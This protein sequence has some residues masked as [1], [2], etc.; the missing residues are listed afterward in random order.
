[1][2]RKKRGKWV[3]WSTYSLVFLTVL[4]IGPLLTM[5]SCTANLKGHWSTANRESTKQAPDPQKNPE[6]V[7]QVYAARAYS[8]RGIFGVHMWFAVKPAAATHY[9][10]YQVLGWRAR[11][12]QSVVDSYSGIPDRHWFGNKPDLIVDIR[13]A[14]A[15][16]I[17]PQIAKAAA[18]YPYADQYRIWPGPN[19]NTFIAHI[20]REVPELGLSM[21]A[22]AI[23][24]DFLPNG[25]LIAQTPSGTGYH[26]SIFGLLGVGVA[27]KEGLEFN[28]LGLTFGI[29]FLRPAIKLP[30]IGRI[31]MNSDP[32]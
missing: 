24:K 19:S 26:V 1:M 4:L 3:K 29:D 14:R 25:N 17:I 30:G 5:F 2:K 11:R 21:P 22:N 28:F 10:M 6:A 12:G 9:T 7:V 18:S 31:G 15:S 8:W 20:G 32:G 23:G 13:G 16:K 27:L